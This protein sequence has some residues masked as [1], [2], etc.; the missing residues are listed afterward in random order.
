MQGQFFT[1]LREYWK[2]A[3]LSLAF[4]L[5]CA[6]VPV[7]ASHIFPRNSARATLTNVFPLTFIG[8]R[9]IRMPCQA[10]GIHLFGYRFDV[11]FDQKR[12]GMGLVCWSIL[13]QRWEWTF[14]SPLLTHLDSD[15]SRK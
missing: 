4:I 7:G 12:E 5:C 2:I 9:G 8:V 1:A 13:K 11:M 6:L 14:D 3:A 10:H 15:P